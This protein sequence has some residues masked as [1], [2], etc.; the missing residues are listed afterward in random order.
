[1]LTKFPNSRSSPLHQDCKTNN[2][3]CLPLWQPTRDA[4]MSSIVCVLL[5]T[6]EI[7]EQLHYVRCLQWTRAASAV[8]SKGNKIAIPRPKEPHILAF[9]GAIRAAA[10]V[11]FPMIGV[12]VDL[13]DE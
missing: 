8:A 11:A 13:N 12:P 9:L 4:L 10:R 1:M 3:D 6:A 2:P 5:G 7:V